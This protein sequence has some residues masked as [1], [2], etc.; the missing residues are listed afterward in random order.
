MHFSHAFRVIQI[1]SLHNIITTRRKKRK[2]EE[3][4]EKRA[5]KKLNKIFERKEPRL[6]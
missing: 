1:D 4:R 2:Q 6:L 5:R 3:E